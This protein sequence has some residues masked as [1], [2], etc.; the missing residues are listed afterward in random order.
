[1]KVKIKKFV[2]EMEVKKS[3]MELEVR[4]P[5]GKMQRGDCYIT[6]SGLVW[7]QGKTAKKNGVQVSWDGF[8]TLMSSKETLKR[9]LETAKESNGSGC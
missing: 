3:G 2:V 7:C 8:M 6:M 1:M 4:T 9:A 5:N